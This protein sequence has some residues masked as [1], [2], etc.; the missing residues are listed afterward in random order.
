LTASA[1]KR[2][3]PQYSSLASEHPLAR[4][5]LIVEVHDAGGASKP[6]DDIEL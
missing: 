1:A 4:F 5:H 2:D 6:A 3:A